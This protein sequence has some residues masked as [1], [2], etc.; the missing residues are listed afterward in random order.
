VI[1]KAITL[2][3][4]DTPDIQAI[5]SLGEGWVGEEAL[6][7]SIYCALKYQDDFEKAVITAVN[8]NGDSDSTGAITGNI[9]GAYLG[10]NNIPENWVR[11]VELSEEL[12]ILADDLVK[13]FEDSA[14]WH[15]KYPGW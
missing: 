3:I 15:Q 4:S 12:T 13:R 7:I 11:Q 9:L 5:E 2:A 14:E 10:I 1:E 8:H 6:A